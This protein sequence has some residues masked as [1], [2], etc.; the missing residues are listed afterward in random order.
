LSAEKKSTILKNLKGEKK[1]GS[2]AGKVG[3]KKKGCRG[4][5][6]GITKNR[7]IKNL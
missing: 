7:V 1:F 2:W 5:G 3:K 6:W 4:V